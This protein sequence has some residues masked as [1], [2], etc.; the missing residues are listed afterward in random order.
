[1]NINIRFFILLIFAVITFQAQAQY[2]L[3][4]NRVVLV[5]SNVETVPAGKVWKVEG[6]V[7]SAALPSTISTS[8]GY[9]VYSNQD[10]S[11]LINGNSVN[12]RSFRSGGGYNHASTIVWEEKWP[13][14]LGAG[15]TLAASSN[16]LYLSVI[17]FNLISP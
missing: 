4:F 5:G 3:E 17:E 12:I 16:V 10:A 11:M 13:V 9:G 2:A 15:N 6:A 8:S 1:M 7:Y 14:W